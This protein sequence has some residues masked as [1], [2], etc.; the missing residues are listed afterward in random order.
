M[1]FLEAIGGWQGAVGLANAA[2]NL[3]SDLFGGSDQEYEQRRLNNIT[4]QRNADLA[5]RDFARARKWRNSNVQTVVKDARKAGINPHFAIGSGATPTSGMGGGHSAPRLVAPQT[6]SVNF[7]QFSDILTGDAAQRRRNE[8]LQNDLLE[9]EIDNAKA[10]AATRGGKLSPRITEKT[11]GL[12]ASQED[13]AGPREPG[14]DTESNAGVD[15]SD[16]EQFYTAPT[17]PDA[18]TGE[19]RYGEAGGLVTGV[20][21]IID[22]IQYNDMLHHHSRKHQITRKEADKR[23]RD[24]INDL[25]I[26]WYEEEVKDYKQWKMGANNVKNLPRVVGPYIDRGVDDF[27]EGA[28]HGP[29]SHNYSKP[30]GY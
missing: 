8:Q 17:N 16:K 2:G 27:N 5:D 23:L 14:R 9:I 24:G 4:F 19:A 11:E 7:D 18:E 22:D 28:W 12:V 20:R 21:N 15:R 13:H 29:G 25:G 10:E 30:R 26:E 6:R 1:A 3:A